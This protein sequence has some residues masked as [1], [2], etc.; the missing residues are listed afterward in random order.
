[1][2]F[3]L[4]ARTHARLCVPPCGPSP[5]TGRPACSLRLRQLHD[6]PDGDGAPVRAHAEAREAAGP[7][8]HRHLSP[9]ADREDAEGDHGRADDLRGGL[10][11]PRPWVHRVDELGDLALLRH[12]VEVEHAAEA[13]GDHRLLV[14][15]VHQPDLRLELC[16]RAQRLLP[17]AERLPGRRLTAQEPRLHELA[18]RR[19]ADLLAPD[20]QGLRP[21]LAAPRHETQ[22]GAR[23]QLALLHAA[24]H[25]H[26]VALLLAAQ[27]GDAQRVAR[28]PRWQRGGLE[29]L[30]QAASGVPPAARLALL[31]V[32]PA[33]VVAGRG[34]DR[35]EGDLLIMVA[36]PPECRPELGADL[37]VAEVAPLCLA[38][39]AIHLVDGDDEALDAGALHERRVLTRLPALRQTGLQLSRGL[40]HHEHREVCLRH[41][42]PRLRHAALLTRR[43]QEGET[44]AFRGQAFNAGGGGHCR[45]GGCLALLLQELLEGPAVPRTPNP[46]QRSQ[47]RRLPCAR[48]AQ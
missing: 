46:Q 4:H 14:G 21:A 45:R 29:D 44:P 11:L 7:R 19:P 9:G 18:R 36:D 39:A 26:G 16:G 47:Q 30:E 6:L 1:M 40:C 31:V 12:L 43:V 5:P 42:G 38:V 15:Q 35:D 37:L 24:G 10:F 23:L 2:H 48:L 27:D 33:E 17:A 28:S 3:C 34:A 20:L 13:L 32:L 22:G 25:D 8:L 41:G